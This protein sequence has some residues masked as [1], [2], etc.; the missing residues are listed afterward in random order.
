LARS[1]VKFN[2]GFYR[3]KQKVK[4][5]IKRYLGRTFPKAPSFR[6][7]TKHRVSLTAISE[8]GIFYRNK[9]SV[10]NSFIIKLENNQTPIELETKIKNQV[11]ESGI[12]F[13]FCNE[14]PVS[15]GDSLT[16]VINIKFENTGKTIN[17]ELNYGV[18]NNL[19][20]ISELTLSGYYGHFILDINEI[21]FDFFIKSLRE[22]F[23][24]KK[25]EFEVN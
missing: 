3:P 19:D 21:G 13:E 1:T 22:I 18:N 6:N 8:L 20:K 25:I 11:F 23:E 14:N 12:F 10:I 4:T 5:K 2:F 16:N 24:A 7:R 9:M 15:S 17:A